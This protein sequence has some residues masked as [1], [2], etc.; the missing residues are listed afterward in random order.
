MANKR[1]E[2]IIHVHIKKSG[3]NY[4][5]GSISAIFSVLSLEQ[6]GISKL[7]ELY[8]FDIEENKPFKNQLCTIR[9][10]SIIRLKTNRRNPIKDNLDR[11]IR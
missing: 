6:I 8:T 11:I 2:K 7:K 9:K 4:Y 5:F 3:K 1:E 10:A